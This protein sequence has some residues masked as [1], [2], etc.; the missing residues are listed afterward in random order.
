[1]VTDIGSGGIF[2]KGAFSLEMKTLIKSP[3]QPR[4]R[5]GPTPGKAWSVLAKI[6]LNQ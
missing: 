1:M 3:G 4:R 6:V 5:T 2:R